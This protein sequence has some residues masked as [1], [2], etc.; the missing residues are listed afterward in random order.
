[1]ASSRSNISL[2]FIFFRISKAED[3]IQCLQILEVIASSLHSSLHAQILE[4]LPTFCDLLE[5]Q[6]R[7]VRH[8][9]SRGLA[10][11]GAVDGD[12]VLT[13]VVEKV[14]P[15]LGAIDRERMREG[16]IEAVACLVEQMGMSIIPFI[17]LLVIPVL[18]R[19][20][21]TNQSV[22]LVAT[23][24]FA[25]LIRLMPLEGGVPDPPAL[26]PELAEKKVQ[27][28]RFLEQLFDPKK[29]EN[30][31]VQLLN[32]ISSWLFDF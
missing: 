5:H 21:D 28:R 31:K 16:A 29:L 2:V 24:S 11:L 10:A 19:M 14:I 15:M 22:R 13:V 18:G 25:T 30:Y 3:L 9:A 6:L 23:Q 17:V 1:M 12:R 32:M 27:Q 7:A 20:S 26:S 8:M 4:L